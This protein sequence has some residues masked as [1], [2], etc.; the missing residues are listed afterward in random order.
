MDN[1]EHSAI[2]LG[3]YIIANSKKPLTVMAVLKLAYICH[4]WHLALYK[5]PLICSDIEAWKYG[6]V[7]PSLYRELKRQRNKRSADR[8]LYCGT[9]KSSNLFASRKDFINSQ[10]TDDQRVLI[11]RV[12]SEYGD[13]S[14]MDLSSMTHQEGT[15]WSKIYNPSE[16]FRPIPDHVIQAH[17]EDLTRQRN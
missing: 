1:T 8:L 11:D 17:Y 5:K 3:D 14:A 7:I 10:F 2:M 13:F 6:P 16:P 9:K 15:P 12:L 4:G